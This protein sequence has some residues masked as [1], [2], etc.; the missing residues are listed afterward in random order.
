MKQISLAIAAFTLGATTTLT[1]NSP[2]EP[3]QTPPDNARLQAI[4]DEDQKS[5]EG[6]L[7]KLDWKKLLALDEAHRKEVSQMLLEGKVQTAKDYYNAAMVFQHA[8]DKQ[9]YKLAHELAWISAS[10]GNKD[11]KWLSA[12]AWDR[13]LQ[14]VNEKQRFGTQYNS[15]DGGPF[16]LGETDPEVTDSMRKALNCPT[17][18]QAKE[19]EK[20]FNGGGS[21]V[22]PKDRNKKPQ[23]LLVDGNHAN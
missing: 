15:K 14:S 13:F 8:Q 2:Q 23:T 1:L 4:Y 6:D 12:A 17:L 5:R 7:Q 9:G 19:R 3:P 20:Q 18:Q 11:A 10:M 22:S 16:K 21:R